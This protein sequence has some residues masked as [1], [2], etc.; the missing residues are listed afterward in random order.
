MKTAEEVKANGVHYTPQPLAEF[1]ARRA[2]A[3]LPSGTRLRV[4]DPACGDGGLLEAV[5]K[6]ADRPDRIDLVGLDTDEGAIDQARRRLR[7]YEGVVGSIELL[8]GDFLESFTRS[9]PALFDDSAPLRLGLFDLAISNPPYVRT[10]VLGASKSQALA[11]RFGLSGRVDLYHAF[12]IGLTAAL[13]PGGS[14]GLLCSN[15]FL[16]TRTGE[17]LRKSLIGEYELVELFDLGDTKLF[18]AAVLPAVLIARRGQQ[19]TTPRPSRCRFA[20]VYEVRGETVERVQ[21]EHILTE[22]EVGT[23]GDV[24]TAD[25]VFRIEQGHLEAT[26]PGRPWRIS[27]GA[28]AKF[29]DLIASRSTRTFSD[30]IK[31]RV[32]I[33]TTADSVFIRDD[34][35]RLPPELQPEPALMKPIVMRDDVTK[36]RTDGTDTSSRVLYP[37]NMKSARREVLGLDAFPGAAA[38]LESHRTRLAGRKY[39]IDAGRE[40]FEIWVPQRPAEWVLPKLVFPDISEFPR[41]AV[42]QSG[43]IVNGTCYWALA[44]KDDDLLRVLLGVANSSLGQRFYDLACGNRLYAGR[45][46]YMTQYVDSFPVP[47]PSRETARLSELVDELMHASGLTTHDIR[48]QEDA[49]DLQVLRAFG[50]P[51]D[52]IR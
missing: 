10:Q 45:R 28:T 11:E 1:L 27:S 43:A 38:Y 41:F 31:I 16:S 39:V 14:L 49:V 8:R 26:Q 29:L 48:N 18:E 5:A 35:E 3:V 4:L 21:A 22:L 46:R 50:L 13:K 17:G 32:G 9:Q 20:R 12:A 37:Y 25:G 23:E 33:K 51:E 24:E 34:W 15:R 36:W 52:A 42:D 19:G 40:W 2:L 7:R 44:P 6:A 47:E 30:V